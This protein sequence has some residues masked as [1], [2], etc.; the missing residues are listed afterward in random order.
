MWDSSPWAPSDSLYPSRRMREDCG[1]VT[2]RLGQPSRVTSALNGRDDLCRLRPPACTAWAACSPTATVEIKVS[3]AAV[4]SGRKGEGKETSRRS[5]GSLRP[6]LLSGHSC[7]QEAVRHTSPWSWPG[8]HWLLEWLNVVRNEGPVG[9][10]A[11]FHEHSLADGAPRGS[12]H[13]FNPSHA[14]PF[15]STEKSGA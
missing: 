15:V 2:A 1:L 7:S 11:T 4:R 3:G 10:K 9:F 5:R 12:R 8:R 14:C 6:S 13:R